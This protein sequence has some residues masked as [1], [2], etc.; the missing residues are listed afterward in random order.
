MIVIEGIKY[1]CE[2]CIRGHRVTKCSHSDGPLVAIKPKGRPSTIC[3]YCKDLKKNHNSNPSGACS[4]GRQKKLQEKKEKFLEDKKLKL[5]QDL[6]VSSNQNN[7]TANIATM[8]DDSISYQSS[9]LSLDASH[10]LSCSCYD[11]GVCN[12]HKRKKNSQINRHRKNTHGISKRRNSNNSFDINSK[13]LGSHQGDFNSIHSG[14]D[15]SSLYSHDSFSNT[16]FLQNGNTHQSKISPNSLPGETPGLFS[17]H[18]FNHIS[19]IGLNNLDSGSFQS[20]D[21]ASGIAYNI[22]SP[23]S[24]SL[25]INKIVNDDNFTNSIKSS[26]VLDMQSLQSE[27][28]ME[29][30]S[31]LNSVSNFNKKKLNNNANF[32]NIDN[33]IVHLNELRKSNWQLHHNNGGKKAESIYSYSTNN[34]TLTRSKDSQALNANYVETSKNVH[35]LLDSVDDSSKFMMNTYLNALDKN[36]L[37]SR[38]ASISENN[39]NHYQKNYMLKNNRGKSGKSPL[40]PSNLGERTQYEN[41][42]NFNLRPGYSRTNSK[43]EDRHLNAKLNNHISYNNNLTNHNETINEIVNVEES[44]KSID[45]VPLFDVE[46][47]NIKPNTATVDLKLFDDMIFDSLYD[48]ND[49]IEA[50]VPKTEASNYGEVVAPLRKKESLLPHLSNEF[51]ELLDNSSD[52]LFDSFSE[53]KALKTIPEKLKKEKIIN[54]TNE[55]QVFPDEHTEAFVLSLRPSSFGLSNLLETFRNDD[56]EQNLLN[57]DKTKNESQPL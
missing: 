4:C 35:G 3:E 30:S 11:T 32:Q 52:A 48:S 15:N 50:K 19:S 39:L 41:N 29:F 53:A 24:N 57:D 1:A 40:V 22:A 5:S 42:S 36:A 9:L 6:G 31:S 55:N 18:N 28:P 12:C 17:S 38:P 27:V 10:L 34:D 46:T 56:Y 13:I 2:R 37:N 16:V 25:N 8:S 14:I 20:H 33:D 44:F 47:N 54:I 26:S 23:S 7:Y 51:L 45:E 21:A 43:N 49:N